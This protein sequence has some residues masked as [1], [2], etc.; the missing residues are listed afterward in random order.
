MGEGWL[1]LV[2]EERGE[3][4]GRHRGWWMQ[5][6]GESRNA[7]GKGGAAESNAPASAAFLWRGSCERA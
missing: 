5:E 2:R 1:D 3:G 4:G 7:A 6:G